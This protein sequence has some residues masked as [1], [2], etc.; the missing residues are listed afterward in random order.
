MLTAL[1]RVRNAFKTPLPCSPSRASDSRQPSALDAI[2]Q[3]AW[4]TG[5]LVEET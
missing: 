1:R 2:S 5:T 4:Y 3:I